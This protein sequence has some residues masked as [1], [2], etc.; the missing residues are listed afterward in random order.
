MFISI[1]TG[2]PLYINPL[3]I[4]LNNLLVRIGVLKQE[5]TEWDLSQRLTTIVLILLATLPTLFELKVET[6]LQF[7]VA[8]AGSWIVLGL[9]GLMG[10]QMTKGKNKPAVRAL[11]ILLLIS[12]ALLC[13]L[14]IW[15]SVIDVLDTTPDNLPIAHMQH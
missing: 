3:R 4:A 6:V 7:A 1:F 8:T 13:V 9:P 12:G 15:G 11:S 2:F 5:P 10:W 14:G